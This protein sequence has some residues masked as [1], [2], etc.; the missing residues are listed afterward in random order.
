MQ[1]V[2]CGLNNLF[3]M[4]KYLTPLMTHVKAMTESQQV[5][6][7][8]FNI[9]IN[10]RVFSKRLNCSVVLVNCMKLAALRLYEFTLSYTVVKSSTEPVLSYFSI[11]LSGPCFFLVYF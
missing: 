10:V 1:T 7:T 5:E 6:L 11:I 3:S 4:F 8:L 2:V 9:V